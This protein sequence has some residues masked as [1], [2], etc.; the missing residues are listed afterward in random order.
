MRGREVPWRD[1]HDLKPARQAYRTQFGS[2]YELPCATCR[3][4]FVPTPTPLDID[5]IEY[6][7]TCVDESTV[8]TSEPGIVG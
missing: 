5:A 8:H 4:M 6:S 7:G 2:P 3:L 1:T